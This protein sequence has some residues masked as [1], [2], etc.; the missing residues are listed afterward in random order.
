[1]GRFCNSVG[2]DVS[3][4]NKRIR[5]LAVLSIVSLAGITIGTCVHHAIRQYEP[6]GRCQPEGMAAQSI[7]EMQLNRH[8]ALGFAV[9]GGGSRAAYLAAAVLREIHRGRI[10]L[11]FPFEETNNDHDLLDQVDAVSAVSGGS[12]AATYFVLHSAQLRRADAISHDWQAYLN[13]MAVS[14]RPREWYSVTPSVWLKMLFSNYN[15]GLLARDDYDRTLFGGATLADLPDRPFEFINA[16]DIANRVRFVFSKHYI[17]TARHQI[18]YLSDAQTEAT[19]GPKESFFENDLF[20]AQILPASIKLADAVYASSAYPIAYPNFAIRNCNQR[21]IFLGNLVFLADGGLAD[22]S[23]LI[24]LLTRFRAA[25]HTVERD[26]NVLVVYIDAS[27]DQIGSSLSWVHSPSS[28]FQQRGIEDKYAWQHTILGHGKEAIEGAIDMLQEVDLKYVEGSGVEISQHRSSW[29]KRLSTRTGQCRRTRDA[30][31]DSY[32]E[33]GEIALRPLVI[34]LG[35]RDVIGAAR[36]F[37]WEEAVAAESLKK[38]YKELLEKNGVRKVV[39]GIAEEQFVTKLKGIRTDLELSESSRDALDL[40][41]F[42]LVH[43]KLRLDLAAWDGIAGDSSS[44]LP[45]L[46]KVRC[47]ERPDFVFDHGDEF[48]GTERP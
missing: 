36:T 26:F 30:S 22:N 27:V 35:L 17:D 11:L 47:S 41:A 7:A 16:F 12:L 8:T 44:L 42:L 21:S 3:G 37:S 9:S 38:L 19:K 23:G 34:R 46:P 20:E 43:G 40:A 25:R 1:V 18:G 6:V 33:T 15:R 13:K 2:I 5:R 39:G 4:M 31:W 14:Y 48:E 28:L 29:K 45:N 10:K 24:T 32:F